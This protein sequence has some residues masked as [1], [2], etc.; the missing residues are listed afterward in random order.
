MEEVDL[1]GQSSHGGEDL[2]WL[3]LR[4][5]TRDRAVPN[6]IE[7]PRPVSE[8]RLYGGLMRLDHNEGVKTGRFAA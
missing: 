3:D 4:D 5:I 7:V 2:L 1:P 6:G 8:H